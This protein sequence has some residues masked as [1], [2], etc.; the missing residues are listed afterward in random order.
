M[1]LEDSIS[2]IDQDR[3]D[4]AEKFLHQFIAGSQPLGHRIELM[5]LWP[6]DI[7]NIRV[8]NVCGRQVVAYEIATLTFIDM[9]SQ[10]IH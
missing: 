6:D 4:L 8:V 9:L 3:R 10:V 7:G 5:R 2:K 1:L